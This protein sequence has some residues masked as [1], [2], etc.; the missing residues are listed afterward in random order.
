MC[1]R[2]ARRMPPLTS[3][4]GAPEI[5]NVTTAIATTMPATSA[6]VL[7]RGTNMSA[8]IGATTAALT[9]AHRDGLSRS[10]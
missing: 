9:I 2:P 4:D 10:R 8:A 3:I 1:A 5:M 6:S 7:S